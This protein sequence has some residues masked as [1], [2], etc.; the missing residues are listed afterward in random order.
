MAGAARGAGAG[1]AAPALGTRRG[2][3]GRL[4]RVEIAAA[5]CHSSAVT[6]RSQHPAEWHPHAA[7]WLAWPSHPAEWP[8]ALD[9]ARR[10]VAEM[11]T[12][13]T[14]SGERV[15]LLVL[16]GESQASARAALDGAP[17]ALLHW[18]PEIPFGDVW[19]RDTGPVFL[20]GSD[21]ALDAACFRWSG[22]A[23]KFLFEHD[24]QVAG[25]IA[26]SAGARHADAAMVLEG[27]AIET[28]GQGT[29]LTTRQCLL[30]P[31]R[32]PGW[33]EAACEHGLAAALGAER[34]VWLDRGLA[35]D[36]TDGHVDTL[37]RFVA[38]GRVICMAPAGPGDP[39]REVLAE[40]ARDLAA[41]R[42]ARGRALEVIQVPSP[43]R[44]DNAA[45]ELLAASYVNFLIGNRVVLVPVYGAPGDAEVVSVLA[46]LFPGR[47]VVAID[48]RAAVTGGGALHCMSREQPDPHAAGQ[49]AT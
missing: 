8:G 42:D 3:E 22:W 39:N 9:G 15:N 21:G 4:R 26:E 33:D 32:N 12:A 5:S 10:A 41:A 20:L 6:D 7:T 49:E 37:A 40:V 1:G 36:H 25:R 27:G 17:A 38:P 45:G 46:R 29:I 14:R 28:D 23:G 19:L 30:H 18:H 24:D 47:E 2:R 16:P 13:L 43:G 31:G 34:V 11:A 48:A 44:I 35:N